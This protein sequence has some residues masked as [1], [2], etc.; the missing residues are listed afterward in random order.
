[1]F[2]NGFINFNLLFVSNLTLIKKN[3][4]VFIQRIKLVL[5]L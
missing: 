4:N 3:F 5:P 2:Y 1:M